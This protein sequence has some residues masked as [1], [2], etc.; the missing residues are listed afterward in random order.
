MEGERKALLFAA[1]KERSPLEEIANG[2]HPKVRRK[3]D[4]ML[5]AHV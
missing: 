5:G 3:L 1:G 4:L 2:V